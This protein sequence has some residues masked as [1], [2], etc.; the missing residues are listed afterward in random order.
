MVVE[1]DVDLHH[2][3]Y[4]NL[5]DYLYKYGVYPGYLSNTVMGDKLYGYKDI[6]LF[7]DGY[8]RSNMAAGIGT[9][10]VSI[11]Y[12][13]L[14]GKMWKYDL[15]D[16]FEAINITID[17][18]IF[19][20]QKRIVEPPLIPA[21]FRLYDQEFQE[22]QNKQR[23]NIKEQLNQTVEIEFWIETMDDEKLAKVNEKNLTHENKKD[24]KDNNAQS[25]KKHV[26][27]SEKGKKEKEIDLLLLQDYQSDLKL[28]VKNEKEF[29]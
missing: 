6:T 29:A 5:K 28:I 23:K 22:M 7:C 4:D 13:S 21:R 17:K 26:H 24:R 10:V 18:L 9:P 15:L 11:L 19:Q 12:E 25:G 2:I 1:N 14:M 8:V 16:V 20:P 3:Q 27:T